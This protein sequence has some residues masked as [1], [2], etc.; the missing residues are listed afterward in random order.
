MGHLV[1]A[2]EEERRK[3][4]ADIHD[5]LI[6]AMTAA[7]LRLQQLRKHATSDQQQELITRLDE[8]VRESIT[9]LRRLMFDLGP[10][11]LDRRGL[12]PALR[13]LLDRM[14]P[15][16]EIDYTLD[17]RL[18]TEPSSALRIELY[19]ITQEALTNRRKHARS[20]EHTSE[21]QS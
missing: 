19:R 13:E 15:D 4:A 14:R 11:A 9:R 8:A 2:Q 6:Q 20:E 10:P 3:I 18:A 16:I 5:D 17:D 7:S 21:V 12:G 1:Q